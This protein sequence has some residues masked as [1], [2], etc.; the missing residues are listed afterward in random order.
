ML[1][2]YGWVFLCGTLVGFTV[3]S[4]FFTPTSSLDSTSEISANIEP[5]KTAINQTNNDLTQ[6]KQY[7]DQQSID[8]TINSLTSRQF[9]ASQ[10]TLLIH[11]LKNHLFELAKNKSWSILGEWLQAMELAGLADSD[12]YKLQALRLLASGHYYKGL[13]VFFV[14]KDM[15]SSQQEQN[16]I[17]KEI[18]SALNQM[19][20]SFHQQTLA[21]SN[22]ETQQLFLYAQQ[23]LNEYI[24]ISLALANVYQQ[25][26]ALQEALD[27]LAF[28]PYDEQ[29]TPRVDELQTRLRN[30]LAEAQLNKEGI[31]LIRSGSQ[32]LVEVQ[33]AQVNLVLLIDT[34][35]SYT[36]LSQNAIARLSQESDALSDELKKVKVNT[37]NGTTVARVFSV[38]TF[39][40]A[41]RQA[42]DLSVLEV[43]M[44]EHTRSDGLLGMN[45]LG[46][47]HFKIDQDNALLFLETK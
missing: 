8:L 27:A 41:D 28:L 38:S 2:K 4:F 1:I 13:E 11:Y 5:I 19:I 24:P 35:A 15:A 36:S 21:L 47:Y 31:P 40:L 45:F 6:V 33:I 3:N 26:G 34:G 39:S 30:T 20:N 16:K 10:S 18:K 12:S 43:N 29:F 17:V 9:S 44:G 32:F 23:Q 25:Q 37:A 22:E 14:A 46:L 42:E 7:I